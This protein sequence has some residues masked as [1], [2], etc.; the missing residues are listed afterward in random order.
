MEFRIVKST[1][2]DA[3]FWSSL[4]LKLQ[5]G[6]RDIHF[7]PEYGQVYKETYGYEPYL[8]FYGNEKKFVIQPFVTRH[9]NELIFLNHQVLKEDYFDITNPYGYGGPIYQCGSE[10]EAVDMIREFDNYFREYCDSVKIAS[11]FV[12]LHPFMKSHEVLMHADLFPLTKQKEVVYL[13]LSLSYDDL[14]K[15]IRKGHKSSIKKAKSKNVQIKKMESSPENF[16]ELNDLYYSTMERN[17]AAKRW[18]FPEN[19]FYNCYKL[20]G[21]NRI[22]LYFAYVDGECATAGIFMHDFDTIYYHFAGSDEKFFDYCPNNLLIYEVALRAKELGYKNFHLGGGVSSGTND[23]LYIFKSGF[24]NVTAPLYTYSRI[25]HFATY[26][27]LCELKKKYEVATLG[28]EI[29]S[30]Y[31]P[32]YRR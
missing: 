3:N 22:S 19:Y 16:Q 12:S 5:P 17:K 9:L 30:D 18:Y 10:G 4:I 7:I 29:E 8:A 6:Q 20:L 15:G 27:L 1:G 26:E 24:S 23:N 14:W 25:H 21:D 31:F 32:L 13:D 28:A 2:S 11:E